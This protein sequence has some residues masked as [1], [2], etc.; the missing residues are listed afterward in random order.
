MLDRSHS[1]DT[2]VILAALVALHREVISLHR[3]VEQ[4]CGGVPIVDQDNEITIQ[5]A[6]ALCDRTEQCLRN[7]AAKVGRF[8][9]F[10][11]RYLISKQKLRWYLL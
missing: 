10:S 7:W 11:G 9:A 2:R 3:L 4:Q 5:R 1:P 8:D 6:A